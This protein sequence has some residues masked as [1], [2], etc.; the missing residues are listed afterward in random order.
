MR[1]GG[2]GGGGGN[3]VGLLNGDHDRELRLSGCSIAVLQAWVLSTSPR[4]PEPS[5]ERSAA[6]GPTPKTPVA[7][8]RE[9]EA[10][11]PACRHAA[12]SCPEPQAA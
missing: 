9:L 3:C 4:S 5:P 8:C 10:A 11:A 2:G 7:G 1:R 12:G 6:R